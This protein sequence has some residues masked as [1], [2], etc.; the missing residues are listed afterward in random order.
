MF[1]FCFAEYITVYTVYFFVLERG[2]RRLNHARAAQVN[3]SMV[4]FP[5]QIWR[6]ENDS[7]TGVERVLERGVEGKIPV[8]TSSPVACSVGIDTSL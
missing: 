5:L 1:V 4:I 6:C 3:V 2:S 7:V 8:K